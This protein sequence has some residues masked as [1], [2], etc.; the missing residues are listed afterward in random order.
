[1]MQHH[2]SLPGSNPMLRQFS[3]ASGISTSAT[4]STNN[5]INMASNSPQATSKNAASG[6]QM[7]PGSL[8][9]LAQ[10]F[11]QGQQQLQLFQAE[12]AAQQFRQQ[13]VNQMPP[14]LAA[15]LAANLL[16]VAP[17]SSPA[18]LQ[19][20]FQSGAQYNP[21][22]SHLQRQNGTQPNPFGPQGLAPHLLMLYQQANPLQAQLLFQNQGLFQPNLIQ[23][24]LQNLTGQGVT[25]I[26]NAQQQ[27]TQNPF[28]SPSISSVSALNN[29]GTPGAPEV[30]LQMQ[31][32]LSGLSNNSPASSQSLPQSGQHLDNSTSRQDIYLSIPGADNK[33]SLKDNSTLNEDLFTN[34]SNQA[35]SVQGASYAGARGPLTVAQTKQLSQQQQAARS[36]LQNHRSSQQHDQLERNQN[37]SAR[38]GDVDDQNA[39]ADHRN[40]TCIKSERLEHV[41]DD[42]DS[43]NP[44]ED[45]SEIS[46]QDS[47]RRY[48]CNERDNLSPRMSRSAEST[49]Q[50]SSLPNQVS[51]KVRH[52]SSRPQNLSSS[53]PTV[54]N[55]LDQY[56]S[57]KVHTSHHLHHANGQTVRQ[58][59]QTM[60]SQ[61]NSDLAS[62]IST[63][64]LNGLEEL[65]QFAKTFKQRR[66]KLGFT[67]GDVGMAMGK[68]YGNDFSQT[69]IS[70]F[71]A[72]NLSFKNMCKLKPL[73]HRWLEDASANGMLAP[74][75]MLGAGNTTGS[76][77]NNSTLSAAFINPEA[78]GRRRKKRTSIETTVRVALEK[79]FLANPKPTSEEITLLSDNLGMEKEV[80]RVW[81]CNR[82]QK[83]KRINPPLGDSEPGS[84]DSSLNGDTSSNG[85]YIDTPHI[86]STI[87]YP[88]TSNSGNML[89]NHSNFDSA[90]SLQHHLNL[91][92]GLN[93]AA[94]NRRHLGYSNG[95]GDADHQPH[96]LFQREHNHQQHNHQLFSSLAKDAA[97]FSAPNNTSSEF[98]SDDVVGNNNQ[99]ADD[100]NSVDSF[101]SDDM[102][103]RTS[104]KGMRHSR[105]E[106][107][108]KDLMEQYRQQR[109]INNADNTHSSVKDSAS[110]QDPMKAALLDTLM[111]TIGHH[112][113]D[114]SSLRNTYNHK[115]SR[116]RSH[117]E[118]QYITASEL[119][120]SDADPPADSSSSFD[121]AEFR[122]DINPLVKS[123]QNTADDDNKTAYNNKRLR[124]HR[125]ESHAEAN[126]VRTD[127]Y[128][129]SHENQG[130]DDEEE[131]CDE[132]AST[133][134]TSANGT[135]SP[136][137]KLS[138][139]MSPDMPV[140][141]S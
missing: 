4:Q 53:K 18:D 76:T 104:R 127:H 124:T 17:T 133:S 85:G 62:Q 88:P 13:V 101:S 1:M 91:N 129:R 48:V 9:Q 112:M 94:T 32:L 71:E 126:H 31:Q 60:N 38:P 141:M 39:L 29:T 66:I 111:D 113:N 40:S 123:E 30:A 37:N 34:Y 3:N 75:G 83:E 98:C 128:G 33:Q 72:L 93:L 56:S 61:S 35:S 26:N 43:N 41:T 24:S 136:I 44:D 96:H 90:A 78:I 99:V 138:L 8:D 11:A 87:N 57:S 5:D 105:N 22:L 69:T 6:S 55:H 118:K 45:S 115:M 36:R 132:H 79:A 52:P 116:K 10:W 89:V 77:S 122:N 119:I 74:I 2:T 106:Q 46:V 107:S 81:F 80:V 135:T 121:E 125:D 12:L 114:D 82:R 47:A 19:Q 120:D 130:S 108:V 21:L 92:L 28:T 65:E 86:G 100:C 95:N 15:Q 131:A 16:S 20:L 117:P 23:Q 50:I 73:L 54:Q 63:D 68:L 97:A 139:A 14:N 51:N 42:Q 102:D 27:L 59:Q 103:G 109:H 70:R 137:T 64:E 7:L 49:P 25:Q 58:Q 140:I 110:E 84:P 67:Q 134:S